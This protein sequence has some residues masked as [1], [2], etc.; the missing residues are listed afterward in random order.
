L[1]NLGLKC[2]F[3]KFWGQSVILGK[4]KEKKKVIFG[5]FGTK[6]GYGEV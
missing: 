5:K 6:V 4:K 3:G 2:D 1:G